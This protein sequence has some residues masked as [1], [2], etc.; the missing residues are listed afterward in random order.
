VTV[1]CYIRVSTPDQNPELQLREL[2]DYAT[3]QGWELAEA[4]ELTAARQ[5]PSDIL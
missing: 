2:R 4:Y 1:A 3:R 5:R